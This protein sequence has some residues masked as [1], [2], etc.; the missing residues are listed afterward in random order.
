[1]FEPLTD[2]IILM[3]ED[4][5]IK[6]TQELLDSNA[7]PIEIFAVTN[8]GIK[9]PARSKLKG[10][11]TELTKTIAVLP[12]VNMSADADNEYFSDGMTEEIITT[13]KMPMW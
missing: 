7:N 9:I 8:D 1:M 12:L 11:Q 13:W 6:I 4:E 5:A 3:K 2:A 10:K